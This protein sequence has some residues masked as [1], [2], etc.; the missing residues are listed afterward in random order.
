MSGEA[1]AFRILGVP[2]DAELE[3]IRAAY[4][5]AALRCHP[6]TNPADPDEAARMFAR[7]TEAYR[8]CLRSHRFRRPLGDRQPAGRVSPQEFAAREAERM[9]A[10]VDYMEAMGAGR[11]RQ[12]GWRK[13]SRPRLDET[14]AFVFLWPLGVILALG[15][16][17]LTAGRLGD[18]LEGDAGVAIFMGVY[19]LVY[20]VSL[21]SIIV[22]LLLTRE[23]VILALQVIGY[24]AR[25]ALP[26]PDPR[27]P[28]RPR[29]WL[30]RWRRS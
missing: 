22:G 23:V 28:R 3:E 25:R 9:A 8:D 19:L 14:R 2:R 27:L 24:C 12:Q 7:I 26:G 17:I 29:W 4:H 30:A 5:R 15:V 1:D 21:V 18:G 10:M 11:A 13:V 6:D 20:A 16:S